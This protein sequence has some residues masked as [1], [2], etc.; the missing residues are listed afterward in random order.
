MV[1]I[2]TAQL[3]Q[4]MASSQPLLTLK[5][6]SRLDPVN[7]WIGNSGNLRAINLT[8]RLEKYLKRRGGQPCFIYLPMKQDRHINIGALLGTHVILGG[9]GGGPMWSTVD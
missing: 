4:V 7:I 2:I 6:L 3:Q 8:W 9:L 1:N 5:K